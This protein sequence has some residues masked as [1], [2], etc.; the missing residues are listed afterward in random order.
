MW[1]YSWVGAHLWR[2]HKGEATRHARVGRARVWSL[3][4]DSLGRPRVGQPACFSTRC[5]APALQDTP[6][7]LRPYQ[8]RAIYALR[9]A[10]AAKAGNQLVVLPP[11]TGKSLLVA[12][13]IRSARKSNPNARILVLTAS[14][15]LVVQNADELRRLCPDETVSM[16]NAALGLRE[17][18]GMVIFGTIQ[19][20]YNKFHELVPP[21]P[22]DLL[23]I[24]EAHL[25]PRR[26][27][28]MFGR[29]ITACTA[30]NEEL[31]IVGLT[32]TPFRLDSGSLTED[33]GEKDALFSSVAYESTFAQAVADGWLCPLVPRA[34]RAELDVSSVKRR[35]HDFD[36]DELQQVL[37]VLCIEVRCMDGLVCVTSHHHVLCVHVHVHVH[38]CVRVC[39]CLCVRAR[40][41]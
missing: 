11:G 5:V 22:P 14:K 41:R 24:D 40:V 37:A 6:L 34:A 17:A 33:F 25:V 10:L 23:I 39:V 18:S 31:Q 15:E 7:K 16:Y 21:P 12:E 27:D 8:K 29:F 2:A 35:G 30:A 13:L 26:G 4:S 3:V 20:M 9:E 1:R 32:A 28:S 38:V 19:S 36:D